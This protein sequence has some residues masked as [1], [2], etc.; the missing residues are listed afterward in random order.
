MI[1]SNNLYKNLS[2]QQK[3][4]KKPVTKLSF[5]YVSGLKPVNLKKFCRRFAEAASKG[6]LRKRC[7]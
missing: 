1:F 4:L 5:R 2:F 6:V 7:P 3:L